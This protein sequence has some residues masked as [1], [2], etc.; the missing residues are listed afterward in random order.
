MRDQLT[1]VS[2]K[3]QP[4]LRVRLVDEVLNPQKMFLGF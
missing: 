3:Q 1:D 4:L 2:N